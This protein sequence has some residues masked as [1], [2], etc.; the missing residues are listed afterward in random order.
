M[1]KMEESKKILIGGKT[2]KR[3]SNLIIQ[4]I[5]IIMAA[6]AIFPFLWMVSTSL[7]GAQEAFAYPPS[8]IPEIFRWENY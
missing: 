2:K 1:Q 7:K 5:L 3:I 8:L 6:L 4:I